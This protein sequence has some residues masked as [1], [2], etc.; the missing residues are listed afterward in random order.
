MTADPRL[1]D[2]PMR[3][4]LS[5][6]VHARPPVD[7]ETP[8]SLSYIARVMRR[9]AEA[10]T[11]LDRIT[12]L[13]AHFG[14][15]PPAA[16]TKQ[17]TAVLEGQRLRWERHTEFARYAFIRDRHE[18]PPFSMAPTTGIPEEWLAGLQDEVMSA[19]HVNVVPMPAETP[20]FNDIS[21]Q[22]F[23]GNPLIGARIAGDRAIA[24]TDFRVP[25]DGFMRLLILNER[26]S[27]AQ[28]GRS[29]QRLLEIDTYRMMALLALPV[30]HELQ[31]GLDSS[32]E[33]LVEI[34]EALLQ[35]GED[36]ETEL[37]ND[38]TFLA[39]ENQRSH[40]RNDYR[41]GAANAYY[42][43]VLQRIAELR[44]ERIPGLPTFDEFTTRRLTPAVNTC[45]AVFDRQ[46]SLVLRMARATQLLST[47]IDVERQRQ[48]QQ[49][50]ESMDRRA[51]SQ[52]RLQATVEGLSV[53]AVT[54]YVVG[55]VAILAKA[56]A[57]RGLPVDPSIATAIS[58]PVIAG[59]A[60]YGVR[61]IRRRI[62]EESSA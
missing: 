38:L 11:E 16:D 10:G 20:Q 5:D 3:R 14:Q 8:G 54:Y 56:L 31:P 47:R 27:A 12:A 57:A 60:F 34:Y 51:R 13:L 33:K 29:V 28:T 35:P 48:N 25:D 52:L 42:D 61:R 62:S 50:L 26:M 40:A 2:H 46:Q 15:A 49:L 6:E 18:D 58:I 19:T 36:D 32:E 24:V 23:D 39:T 1:L 21:E 43:I 22:Y 53:A 55:L 45:R 4:A 7:I 41:F 17:L 30:A 9:D 59:V 37:L 44:E